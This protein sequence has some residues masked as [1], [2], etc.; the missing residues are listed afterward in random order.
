M[1]ESA[2]V[3]DLIAEAERRAPGGGASITAL[4]F[5]IGALSAVSPASLRHGITDRAAALWSTSPEVT[6]DTGSET[7][8]PEASSVVLVSIRVRD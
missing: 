6:I 2:L 4:R 1:H 3:R 5:R 8:T 7:A